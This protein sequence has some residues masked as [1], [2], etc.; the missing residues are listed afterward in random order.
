MA[1][2]MGIHLGHDG[3]VAI[4]KGNKLVFAISSERVTRIKKMFGITP[5]VVNYAL[6]NSGLKLEEID[7]ITFTDYF[8]EYSNGTCKLF[9]NGQ[10]WGIFTQGVVGNQIVNNAYFEI[11]GRKIPAIGVPHHMAHCASAFYTSPFE[12]SFCFSLDSSTGYLAWNSLIAFGQGNKMSAIKCP[13]LMVG[14]LYTKFTYQLGIGDPLHKAGSTMGLA[15]YGNPLNNVVKNI[16]SYVDR[17][18]FDREMI[19]EDEFK[20]FWKEISGQ[21]EGFDSKYKDSRKSMNIAASLQLIFEEA[22]LKCVNSIDNQG[23]ENICLAGGSMLN[24]NVN[25]RILKE[26][27]FKNVH[28]FPGCGDD[29]MSVGSALYIAHN[30]LN[31]PR[32]NYK[33][34]EICYL[35]GGKE[36]DLEIDYSEI[37]QEIKS[38][39]IIAWFNGRSEY[40][41][42]ALGNRSI[43]ADPRNFHTRELLNFVIKKREWFR[44]FAPVILKDKIG[45]WFDWNKESPF[46]LFTAQSKRPSEVPSITHIDGSARMQTIDEETNKHYFNIVKSFYHQT[47]VPMIINTSLN[48]NGEP[49]LETEQ[50]ALN[51]FNNT[52]TDILVLNGKIYRK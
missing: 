22:I 3:G 25:S 13:G 20:K 2:I 9:I 23:L 48:G 14:N 15:S 33:N 32:Y 10:E 28:L 4:V 18:F 5:E 29:G 38:G 19:F 8:P 44:P 40:G 7:L 52:D 43:L 24:C 41:P 35:G 31:E 47:S 21:D 6:N 11:M 39:K 36:T 42:R 16:N 45:N 50:D 17:C 26:S 27:K 30:I 37:A 12:S 51:F 49:V 34:H 1:N 46:M